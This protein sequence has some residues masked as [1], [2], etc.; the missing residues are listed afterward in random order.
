M[1]KHDVTRRMTRI[2]WFKSD[3]PKSMRSITCTLGT[4]RKET[5]AA[6]NQEFP[7]DS[8]MTPGGMYRGWACS[9]LRAFRLEVVPL[10]SS[11]GLKI[12]K[13]AETYERRLNLLERLI[14]NRVCTETVSGMLSVLLMVPTALAVP[15]FEACW[16][17]SCQ[18]Q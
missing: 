16:T 7:K 2:G 6:W 5:K 18:D 15:S 13:T 12:S 17:V 10:E 1:C 11:D 4:Q 3:G 14:L 8:A 9:G